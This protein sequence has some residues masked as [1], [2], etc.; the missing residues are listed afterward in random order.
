[1]PFCSKCGSRLDDGDVFCAKCGSKYEADIEASPAVPA[2]T[3]EESIALAEKL[4]KEYGELEKI[5]KEI[6]DNKTIT[7]QPLPTPKY[8]A[9]FK[10]FWPYLVTAVVTVNVIVIIGFFITM[11]T[12]SSDAYY[13]ASVV[14]VIAMAI[15][16]I[17]GGKIATGKR[18]ALNERVN[19]DVQFRRKKQRSLTEKTSELQSLYTA[20]KN[21]LEKY[22]DLVPLVYRNSR[23]MDRVKLLI[24]T[25]RASGFYDA[26]T[27]LQKEETRI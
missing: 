20:R 9:A 16:L 24:Q 4:S 18:D 25:D 7:S 14:A 11:A 1:M 12:G 2:M 23:H 13:A 22:N 17:A 5:R 19:A 27:L 8:H 3:K 6:N 21:A 15:I 26:F 10:F